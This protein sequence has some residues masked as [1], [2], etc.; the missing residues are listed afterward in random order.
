MEFSKADNRRLRELAGDVYE[1]EVHRLLA[2]LDQ[3]FDAWRK[4][5]LAS[6]ELLQKIHEFHQGESRALWSM[7]QG[8]KPDMVVARGLALNLISEDKVPEPL[9][10]KLKPEIWR[11]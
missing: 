2:Q 10:A 8:L 1:A 3:Q 4:G 9:R 6:S 5:T 7:Y 11:P